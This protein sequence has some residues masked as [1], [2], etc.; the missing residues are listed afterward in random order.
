MKA[1]TRRQSSIRQKNRRQRSKKFRASK[2]EIPTAFI[3]FNNAKQ[4]ANM[5]GDSSFH[6]NG[7]TYERHAWNNGVPVWKRA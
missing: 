1:R 5:R 4:E 2:R 6:W 3:E 7:K